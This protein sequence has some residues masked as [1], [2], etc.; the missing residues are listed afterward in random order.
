M[1][2][3]LLGGAVATAG[4]TVATA[5]PVQEELEMLKVQLR[6]AEETAKRVQ[7]EVLATTNNTFH[8]LKVWPDLSYAFPFC[9]VMALRRSSLSCSR[10]TTAASGNGRPWRR[11]CGAAGSSCRMY[12]AGSGR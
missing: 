10:C 2:L 9:S 8:H 3:A 12:W 11:N 5:G 7:R 4:G 6:L 1:Y